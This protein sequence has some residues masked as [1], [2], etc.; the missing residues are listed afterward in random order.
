MISFKDKN[1]ALMYLA[2]LRFG[3][4]ITKSINY[5]NKNPKKYL[6]DQLQRP[7]LLVHQGANSLD[8]LKQF[9]GINNAMKMIKDTKA[10]KEAQ[11]KRNK[12]IRKSQE[13][14][15]KQKI[16]Q[17]T[18]S[19]TPFYERL[20]SFWSD[21]FCIAKKNQQ[22]QM[23]AGCYEREAIRPHVLGSFE[24]MLIASAQHPAML[25]YLDNANSISKSS[26]A[27]SRRKKSINE[28][29]AREILE[30]HTLGVDKG[31]T[32]N[33]VIA[34]AELISGW[35]IPRKKEVM[36]TQKSFFFRKNAHSRDKI[37]FLGNTFMPK[38][39]LNRG[40][41]ALKLIARHPNTA[42]HISTK[43]ANHFTGGRASVKMIKNLENTFIRTKGNLHA[44][45][46][47]LIQQDEIWTLE[48]KQMIPPIDYLIMI[49]RILGLKPNIKDTG[50]FLRAT[51]QILWQPPSPKGWEVS[52]NNWAS[53]DS[54]LERLR[55]IQHIVKKQR[56]KNIHNHINLDD[57]PIS[58]EV[59]EYMNEVKK[60]SQKL[61]IFLMSP[62][63]IRR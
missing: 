61:E 45:A 17:M 42:T 31:Y 43:M 1:K 55:W 35:S 16:E 10:K 8:L 54:F 48:Q 21:H 63:M 50:K 12:A 26:I 27:G 11:K 9:Y 29:L 23:L 2:E 41:R 39:G 14:D 25:I 33:D 20:V 47:S 22:V 32:Q 58:M 13:N 36:R 30:L 18:F 60:D 4:G 6:S 44:M 37:Y 19:K 57:I 24:N 5:S 38:E 40:I 28:N 15:A 62:M 52:I 3:Y 56:V 7:E 34:L 53:P 49:D 46:L 51:G 59:S